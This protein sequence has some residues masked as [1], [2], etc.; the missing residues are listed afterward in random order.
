MP[1][2]GT[3]KANLGRRLNMTPADTP[4]SSHTLIPAPVPAEG[5]GVVDACVIGAGIAGL[6]TALLLARNGRSVVVVEAG[7][8]GRGESRRTSA[9]L[10]SALDDRFLEL[11]RLHGRTGAALAAE[12][13]AAAIDFIAKLVQDQDIAC[14]FKRVDGY[15]ISVSGRADELQR[16]L[17]AAR[18]A[19][20]QVQE[21]DQVPGV[22]GWTGPALAFAHQAR[23]DPGAYL[24]GLARCCREAGVGFLTPAR[25]VRVDEGEPAEVEIHDGTVI[26]ARDVVVATNV[27][28]NDLLML[29]T[30]LE[31]YRS[32]VIA[33]RVPTGTFPD[34]LLWDDGDPYHYLRLT[35]DGQGDLLVVGGEDHRTGQQAEGAH[36]Y[37]VLEQ[38]T[39]ERFPACGPVVHAW[40]GQ[41]I[42]PVDSLA[43]IGRN[44]GD[45]HIHVITGDSGN[46]LTHGTLGGMLITDLICGRPNPWAELYRPNRLTLVAAG[47]Y[48]GNAVNSMY[49]YRD[50]LVAGSTSD[51]DTIEPEQGAILRGLVN[52]EAV[53]RDAQG[54]LRRCSAICPHLGGLVRWNHQE[55]TWDCPCHGSRFTSHGTVLN[56]PAIADL[57]PLVEAEVAARPSSIP[58]EGS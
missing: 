12:S 36:P 19:G 44:P 33:L 24:D 20:L 14:D 17:V 58:G 52:P 1:R 57:S 16:E 54:H 31:A 10:T 47:D 23:F 2:F 45:R 39:R 40:S 21:V 30:K 50:W 37:Q 5:D 3:I 53:H 34:L 4:W 22:G 41:I 46:G 42:E 35:Q 28:I 49:Q 55:G 32:Y 13:H 11:E 7:T 38:W 26:R 29:H 43:L 27:P 6:T 48:A 51:T 18:R 56:G 15:L 9:H 8:P 25:V